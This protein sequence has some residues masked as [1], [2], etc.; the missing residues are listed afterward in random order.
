VSEQPEDFS[1]AEA[2][3]YMKVDTSTIRRWI[4]RGLLPAQRVGPNRLRI[5]RSDLDSM[6]KP[7]KAAS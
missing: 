5:N 7:V 3:T 4:Y 1:P 2:A 6:S